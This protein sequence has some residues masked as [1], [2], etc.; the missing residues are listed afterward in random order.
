MAS[1]SFGDVRYWNDMG[2]QTPCPIHF[3]L[4]EIKSHL[5]DAE[6][7][8]E[9]QDFFDSIQNIVQRDGW[10]HHETFDEALAFFAD[11][12]S[13]GLKDMKGREREW[14]EERTRWAAEKC[15]SWTF[16]SSNSC[17]QQY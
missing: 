6:S 2:L 11:L 13:I 5:Q 15:S 4:E 10:T 1:F 3:T 17:R 9:V 8:N 14:F 16:E 7:W 12:R